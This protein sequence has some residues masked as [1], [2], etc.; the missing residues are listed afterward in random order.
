M[1][2]GALSLLAALGLAPSPDYVDYDMSRTPMQYPAQCSPEELAKMY[3][4]VVRVP[5]SFLDKAVPDVRGARGV[6]MPS[7]ALAVLDTL[8][9]K[10]LEDTIRHEKCHIL[11]GPWHGGGESNGG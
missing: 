6:R 4:T 3:A 7:G 10:L 8:R 5:Q 11:L 9:G 2:T 1:N